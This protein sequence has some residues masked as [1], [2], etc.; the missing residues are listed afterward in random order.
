M[1]CPY[2]AGVQS[3]PQ[4]LRLQPVWPNSGHV[5]ATRAIQALHG[6]MRVRGFTLTTRIF[7][8]RGSD[9]GGMRPVHQLL[10]DIYKDSG[11]KI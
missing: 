6:I 3:G 5:F 10:A 2:R 4:I 8:C 1:N 7:Y 9:R 11:L